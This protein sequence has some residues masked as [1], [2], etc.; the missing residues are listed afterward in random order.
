MSCGRSILFRSARRSGLIGRLQGFCDVCFGSL[1]LLA[2][3]AC[4]DS[5]LSVGSPPRSEDSFRPSSGEFSVMTYNLNRFSFEDRDGDGQAN[6]FKP[7]DEI[8]AEMAIIQGESPDVLA[9]QEM[10]EAPAFQ[11]FRDELKKRGIEYPHVEHLIRPGTKNHIALLS[12]FPIVSSTPITNET[13]TINRENIPVEHGFLCANIR[14][15]D[16]YQFRIVIAHLKSK[17]FA[18]SGQ[19]EMR[20]NEARLLNKN[21]RHLLASESNLNLIVVGDLSDGPDSAAFREAIGKQQ[22]V[23]SDLRPADSS[24]DVW[25]HFAGTDDTYERVDYILC[26]ESMLR[27][28]DVAKCH[29]VRSGKPLTASSHRPLVAVFHS[30]DL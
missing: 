5:A 26:N 30:R 6:N 13:F 27:E 29:V 20:R 10:G 1:A 25:T 2:L 12:R 21:V 7:D 23:L 19:T 9:C 11:A 16:H 22:R 3:T 18:E 4:S 14:V 8:Q 17:R 24:G 28:T 15:N